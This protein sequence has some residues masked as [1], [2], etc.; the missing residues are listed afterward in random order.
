MEQDVGPAES[1]DAAAAFEALRREVALLNAAVAGLAAERAS[2]PDYSETLGE[3]AKGV[4]V[5]V[6]RLGKVM[7]SPAFV[8]SPADLARQ[9][10]GAGDE[11][12]RQDRVTL[13]QAQEVLQ[14]ATG[15][16]RGWVNTARLARLQNRRLIEVAFIGI[17]AGSLMGVWLPG[18]VARAA[19][20]QWA[21]PEK[22]AA[23]TLRRDLWPAGERL[24]KIADARK[25][26]DGRSGAA[27]VAQNR[28]VLAK[29]AREPR[30]VKR[31]RRCLIQLSS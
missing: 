24:L 11:A 6:G 4:S 22:M 30:P 23:R 20:G 25:W 2:T 27:I 7:T 18:V 28:D 5:A 31:P 16:L 3:I 13:H 15:D 10:A 8:L 21:W 12:R 1:A 14:R 29:C 26:E 17:L 9:I 19:P